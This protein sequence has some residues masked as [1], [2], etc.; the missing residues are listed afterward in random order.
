MTMLNFIINHSL[1]DSNV[2]SSGHLFLCNE[3][4]YDLCFSYDS[5]LLPLSDVSKTL[6]NFPEFPKCYCGWIFSLLFLHSPMCNEPK[7]YIGM[8]CPRFFHKLQN[9]IC[10]LCSTLTVIECIHDDNAQLHNK[11]FITWSNVI[12]WFFFLQ[13]SKVLC[14]CFLQRLNYGVI[15]VL[16]K[17]LWIQV[18]IIFLVISSI[19]RR[20][21]YENAIKVFKYLRW[22]LRQK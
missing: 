12:L 3:C 14:R 15:G 1:H 2:I 19:Y 21:N 8:S 11:S 20:I 9:I 13:V 5:R 4:T 16:K 10:E 17:W 22:T 6:P 18:I 7:S